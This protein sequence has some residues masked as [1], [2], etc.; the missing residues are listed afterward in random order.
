MRF[1]QVATAATPIRWRE[2]AM[3]VL[4]GCAMAGAAAV[5]AL[6]DPSA[7]GSR[8]PSCLFHTTTGL[9][10]P[11]CGLTRGF[12]Q[13]LNGHPLSAMGY[14]LFVPLVLVAVVA[15]W[16]GWLRSAWGRP[17]QHTWSPTIRRTASTVLPVVLVVY[18]VLRNIPL[19]PFRA[20]AP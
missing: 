17:L 9:W 13:L 12:H 16:W 4:C 2:R 8:F 14:N 19:T 15:S 5:V 1:M 18:G 6:N 11:G 20:L 10:C 7:P 3:P